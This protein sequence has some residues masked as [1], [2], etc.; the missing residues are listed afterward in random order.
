VTKKSAGRKKPDKSDLKRAAREIEDLTARAEKAEAKADRWKAEAKR[1]QAEATDSAKQLKKLRKRLD[2]ALSASAPAPAV[3]ELA[4]AT[5][6]V[7]APAAEVE[8][9]EA[10]VEQA[11]AAADGTHPDLTWTVTALRVAA[12]ERGIAGYSRRT[13]AELVG[14]LTE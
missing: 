13:K 6:L 3:G 11:A 7:I 2:A 12:R 9:V 8:T 4:G 1:A 14:L 10:A 5:G